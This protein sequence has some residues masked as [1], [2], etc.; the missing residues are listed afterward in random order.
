MVTIEKED[1]RISWNFQTTQKM[2]TSVLESRK[3]Q[4]LYN[5][6][7]KMWAMVYDVSAESED[8]TQNEMIKEETGVPNLTSAGIYE[9]IYP[10]IDIQYTIRVNVLK[11]TLLLRQ[12]K[13]QRLRLY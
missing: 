1:A 8:R 9:G 7:A 3:F 2:R 13:Q 6:E 4:V 11:R 5:P 12:G 10:D